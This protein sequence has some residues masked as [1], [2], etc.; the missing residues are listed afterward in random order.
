MFELIDKL[1][2]VLN[3]VKDFGAGYTTKTA[4]DGYILMSYKENKYAVKIIKMD[5][6][7]QNKDI[8]KAIDCV[9]YYF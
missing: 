2:M 4:G 7:D 1:H 8:W 5:D 3:M 6:D 9:Q